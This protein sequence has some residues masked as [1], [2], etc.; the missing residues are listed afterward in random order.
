VEGNPALREPVTGAGNN[1]WHRS[2]DSSPDA[3]SV[4]RRP[5]GVGAPTKVV[6][7]GSYDRR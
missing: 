2:S 3:A 5:F 4:A 1:G 7:R 6:G